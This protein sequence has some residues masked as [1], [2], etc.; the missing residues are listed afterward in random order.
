MGEREE[1]K[2]GTNIM[3]ACQ[4]YRQQ[5]AYKCTREANACA[6]I[7]SRSVSGTGWMRLHAHV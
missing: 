5:N 2:E 3:Y 4:L 7:L 6:H 1:R